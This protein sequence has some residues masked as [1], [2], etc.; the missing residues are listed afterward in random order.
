MLRTRAVSTDEP[1]R[2]PV[3]LGPEDA[4]AIIEEIADR[5]V[6]HTAILRA[7]STLTP[8]APQC[9]ALTAVSVSPYGLARTDYQGL[10][11]LYW[12]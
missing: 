5:D 10:S 6:S 7:V 1:S 3:T 9:H 12:R 8:H 11:V 2:M 4:K